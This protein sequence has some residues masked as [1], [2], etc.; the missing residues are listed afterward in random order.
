M[1]NQQEIIEI[2]EKNDETVKKFESFFEKGFRDQNRDI[3]LE[4]I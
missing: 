1:I 4:H 2:K 3:T